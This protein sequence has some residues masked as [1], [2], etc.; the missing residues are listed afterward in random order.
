L[1]KNNGSSTIVSSNSVS[2]VS[3][4]PKNVLNKKQSNNIVDNTL[5]L[6]YNDCSNPEDPYLY[7]SSPEISISDDLDLN[8]FDIE[9]MTV[10][11]DDNFVI[12]PHTSTPNTYTNESSTVNNICYFD[13]NYVRSNIE[14]NFVISSPEPI[15][16]IKKRKIPVSTK[17]QISNKNTRLSDGTIFSGLWNFNENILYC[18]NS[19]NFDSSH[20]NDNR[21]QIPG[22][23]L[24]KIKII[25]GSLRK[26]FSFT[27]QPH[28][29]VC[30]DKSIVEWKGRLQFKQYIPSKRHL[31]LKIWFHS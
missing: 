4:T 20:F 9:N 15:V 19:L 13:I 25:V 3:F 1:T 29:K 16:S 2:D 14:Q 18:P 17:K 21:N 30:V 22:D 11:F 26:K 7:S 12:Y 28:Q 24:F 10:V 31:R 27:Y 5:G 8:S 6:G 23:R